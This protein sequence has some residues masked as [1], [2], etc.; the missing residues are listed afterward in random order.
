[1][2]K[3]NVTRDIN[4]RIHPSLFDKLHKKCKDNYQTVSEVVRQL[5][6]EYVGNK[7]RQNDKQNDK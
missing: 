6:V 1:M 4:I 3:E 5:I 7:G 2:E